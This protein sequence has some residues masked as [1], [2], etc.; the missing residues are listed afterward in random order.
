ME[1]WTAHISARKARIRIYFIELPGMSFAEFCKP[2]DLLRNG[3]SFNGLFLGG[4]PD[5]NSDFFHITPP[6][7]GIKNT[8]LAEMPGR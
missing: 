6:E 2:V 1:R 7:K 4:D 3:I 8:P 5:V